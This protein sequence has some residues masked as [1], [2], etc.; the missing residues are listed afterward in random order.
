MKFEFVEFYPIDDQIREKMDKRWVGTLHIYAIECQL[1]IRG[2]RININK[3][4][5]YFN[6][7]CFFGKDEE[8][9]K[10][11]RYPHIRFNE[12]T[13]TEL[14]DWLKKEVKPIIIKKL[15]EINEA[16]NGRL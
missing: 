2:I 15:R 10:F 5:M 1:D 6:F 11:I 14:M 4:G 12:K 3:N 8:T 9:G 7:P 13:H 16:K